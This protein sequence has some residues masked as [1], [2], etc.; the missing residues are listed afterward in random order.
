MAD[1]AGHPNRKRAKLFMHGG[2]Q[3]VRLPKEF[4][5]EGK[6][7]S[8]RRG[9][10]AVIMDASVKTDPRL[11]DAGARRRMRAGRHRLVAPDDPPAEEVPTQR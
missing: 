1:G 5:F 11:S 10:C 9:A 8:I 2:S 6:E 3:A 7:V 4:R